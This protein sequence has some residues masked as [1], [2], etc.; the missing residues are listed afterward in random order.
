MEESKNFEMESKPRR[1]RPGGFPHGGLTSFAGGLKGG[2]SFS[3]NREESSLHYLKGGALVPLM[4]GVLH[5]WN[6]LLNIISTHAQLAL[7]NEG[8]WT[9]DERKEESAVLLETVATAYRINQMIHGI[10]H[11]SEWKDPGMLD[12]EIHVCVG[13]VLKDLCEILLCE[14]NGFRYPVQIKAR[15]N[16]FTSLSRAAL[17]IALTW[18]VETLLDGLPPSA[19]GVIE[20]EVAPSEAGPIVQTSFLQEEGH[21]PFPRSRLLFPEPFL[22]FVQLNKIQVQE[23]LAGFEFLLPPLPGDGDD[24]QS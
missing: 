20:I 24:F 18:G 22:S 13:T 15:P 12:D 19:P 10:L 21:L 6:N 11:L 17:Y 9:E 4:R 23:N 1:G 16:C 2:R 14:K 5:K 8:N 7:Q 3:H